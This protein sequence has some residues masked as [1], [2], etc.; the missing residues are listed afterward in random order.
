MKVVFILFILLGLI[1]QGYAKDDTEATLIKGFTKW[2]ANRI[3]KLIIDE[4]LESTFKNLYVKKLFPY[5]EK[6]ALNHYGISSERLIPILQ[7]YIKKDIE[8]SKRFV[9]QCIPNKLVSIVEDANGTDSLQTQLEGFI[10]DLNKF[11]GTK[12]KNSTIADNFLTKNGA[13]D[14]NTSFDKTKLKGLIKTVL[15]ESLDDEKKALINK[16]IV[17]V[18]E[19]ISKIKEKKQ[20]IKEIEKKLFEF[21]KDLSKD[22]NK[23]KQQ[24]TAL[25]KELKELIK[26][27]K[28][29]NEALLKDIN[30]FVNIQ[31]LFEKNQETIK[32]LAYIYKDFQEVFNDEDQPYAVSFYKV[33]DILDQYSKFD[34]ESYN[35]F[36]KLRNVGLFLAELADAS[37]KNDADLVADI[38]DRYLSDDDAFIKKRDNNAFLVLPKYDLE[39]KLTSDYRPLKC[40]QKGIIYLSS[41][42]G[43]AYREKDAIEFD[44]DRTSRFIPFGPVGL[45]LKLISFRDWFS[46][47]FNYSPIDIGNYI[48]KE[49]DDEEYDAKLDDIVTKNI[50]FSFS[51]KKYP[52]AIIVGRNISEDNDYIS[53]AYDLPIVTLW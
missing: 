53:I 52:I 19:L 14:N 43:F 3:E 39:K 41:Y 30:Y 50:F 34:L 29:D 33:L 18:E 10:D 36:G 11:S 7:Y 35:Q 51:L 44:N 32:Q 38:L 8:L 25:I 22:I 23:R 9:E 40:P 6:N 31:I 20:E 28:I 26:K 17:K 13:C 27:D 49:L 16:T 1:S 2:Q 21:K 48:A 24:L 47:L 42:Y 46:I 45:E 15:D 12:D 37:D 4:A 5:T